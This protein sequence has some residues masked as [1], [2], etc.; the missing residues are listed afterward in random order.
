MGGTDMNRIVTCTIFALMLSAPALAQ[1]APE[2]TMYKDKPT[3]AGD[4]SAV[5][6]YRPSESMSRISRPDCRPNSEWARVHAADKHAD[7]TDILGQTG[8]GGHVNVMH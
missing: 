8:T 1:T 5:S 4:P 6:C 2:P 3:G 7:Q